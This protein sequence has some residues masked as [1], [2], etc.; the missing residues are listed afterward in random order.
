[1]SVVSPNEDLSAEEESRFFPHSEIEEQINYTTPICFDT[2]VPHGV[3]NQ[4]K[5]D[6]FILGITFKDD[7]KVGHIKE[8]YEKGELLI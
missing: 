8:L 3:T 4:T 2:R 7:Y 1:M 5:E 6:R